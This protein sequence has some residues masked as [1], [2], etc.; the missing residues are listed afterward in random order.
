MSLPSLSSVNPG[1]KQ[2]H[3]DNA[4]QAEASSL[5][6]LDLLSML[7]A[8]D[9]D[10]VMEATRHYLR[11]AVSKSPP[12]PYYLKI[13][14]TQIPMNLHSLTT[15][16]PGLVFK[17]SPMNVRQRQAFDVSPLV[18]F[19]M[20][21]DLGKVKASLS[22]IKGLKIEDEKDLTFVY[23]F[24]HDDSG[25]KWYGTVTVDISEHRR[26]IKKFLETHAT[27][28]VLPMNMAI[29]LI[30]FVSSATVIIRHGA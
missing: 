30:G 1:Q 21:P 28:N 10:V 7:N 23:G 18:Q 9:S 20:F 16:G 11:D 14:E 12:R 13:G 6:M 19:T 22:N 3:P 17:S 15:S 25:W 5:Q 27:P 2:L 4:K 26:D 29:N 8:L 24:S